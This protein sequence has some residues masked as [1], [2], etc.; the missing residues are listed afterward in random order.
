MYPVPRA[1]FVAPRR[2]LL[3]RCAVGVEVV[4]LAAGENKGVAPLAVYFR[5]GSLNIPPNKARLLGATRETVRQFG[6]AVN[7][8]R[9]V[10]AVPTAPAISARH[11]AWNLWLQASATTP[12]PSR[13]S[14]HI[15]HW[16]MELR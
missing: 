9:R 15:E 13:D 12:P 10:V 16:S 2:A 4:E 1:I 3:L 7:E 5:P 8:P 6:H 14:R 11:A